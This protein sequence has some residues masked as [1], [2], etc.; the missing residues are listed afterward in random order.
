MKCFYCGREASAKIGKANGNIWRALFGGCA[1]KKTEKY[2]C[3]A[4]FTRWN[5]GD[6]V[7]FE[8]NNE[9]NEKLGKGGLNGCETRKQ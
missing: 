5:N 2:V 8:W 4:C 3:R 7:W 6:W 1:W 9:R